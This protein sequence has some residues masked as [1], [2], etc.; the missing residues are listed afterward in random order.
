VADLPFAINNPG[1]GHHPALAAIP[2]AIRLRATGPAG[3][4][5]MLGVLREQLPSLLSGPHA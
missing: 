3:W 2:A 5:E 1:T 4:L